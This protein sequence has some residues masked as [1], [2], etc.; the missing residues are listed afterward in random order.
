[1]LLNAWKYIFDM[2]IHFLVVARSTFE[3][4]FVNLKK[5]ILF[6]RLMNVFHN[7][8]RKISPQADTFLVHNLF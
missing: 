1:M 8:H 5:K 2:E 6:S 3:D 7:P 4:G